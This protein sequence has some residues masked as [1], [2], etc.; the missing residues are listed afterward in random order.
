MPTEDGV[1]LSPQE[2]PQGT[3]GQGE[4]CTSRDDAVRPGEL[5]AL[6]DHSG[7]DIGP[8]VE[9][10]PEGVLACR[11]QSI[12]DLNTPQLACQSHRPHMTHRRRERAIAVVLG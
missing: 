10:Q 9:G 4:R 1:A 3:V 8:E 6:F 12:D 5:N 7:P 11:F 2:R